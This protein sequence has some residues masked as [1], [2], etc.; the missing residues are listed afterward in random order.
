MKK[1]IFAALLLGGAALGQ[2]VPAQTPPV[3][4]PASEFARQAQAW[5]AEMQRI[6]DRSEAIWPGGETFR[7]AENVVSDGREAFVL[8]GGG[9]RPVPLNEVEQYLDLGADLA[10]RRVPGELRSVYI[11]ASTDAQNFATRIIAHEDF[12]FFYQPGQFSAAIAGQR[13]T[14]YPAQLRPRALRHAVAER[15]QAAL[16]E[17]DTSRRGALLDQAA[18]LHRAWRAEFPE[19]WERVRTFEV[20]EGSAQYFGERP[21]M[22]AQLSAGVLRDYLQV[23]EP[24]SL[25]LT[26]EAYGFGVLAGLLLE[27]GGVN[28]WQQ[29]VAGGKTPLDVLLSERTPQAA[30][31][32]PQSQAAAERYAQ[33]LRE[34]VGLLLD[35]TLAA[36]EA[37]QPVLQLPLGSRRGS[38]SAQGFFFSPQAQGY[39]LVPFTRLTLE[40]AQGPL[41]IE[42]TTMLLFGNFYGNALLPF[43]PAW[44]EGEVLRHPTLGELQVEAAG[45]LTGRT[46][47]RLRLPPLP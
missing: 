18:F 26:G 44:L 4:A 29:R 22:P 16:V 24:F 20:Y 28:G 14:D 5:A 40:T 12:H 31:V 32:T 27:L 1:L 9:A 10:F 37:G 47:Y 45:E 42:D 7:A 15:L 35:P 2:T 30:E 19:E 36:W 17:E 13:G 25:D 8:R 34:R 41:T 43:D 46:V 3:Q 21:L 6:R 39:T 38:F 33:G 11:F 23:H